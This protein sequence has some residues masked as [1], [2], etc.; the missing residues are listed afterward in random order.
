L[1]DE[2]RPDLGHWKFFF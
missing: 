1:N 2:A